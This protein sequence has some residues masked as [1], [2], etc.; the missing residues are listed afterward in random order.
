MLPQAQG[1]VP[2][3]GAAVAA[4]VAAQPLRRVHC[5]P[6]YQAAAQGRDHEQKRPLL[7]LRCMVRH[8]RIPCCCHPGCCS[9]Q[10][11]HAALLILPVDR[12]P[13]CIA[14]WKGTRPNPYTTPPSAINWPLSG[15][16]PPND[17]EKRPPLKV[18]AGRNRHVSRCSSRQ[19]CKVRLAGELFCSRLNAGQAEGSRG[20]TA[21]A[22]G[23]AGN[24]R[25]C[26]VTQRPQCSRGLGLGGHQNATTQPSFCQHCE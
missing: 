11:Q 21:M 25:T 3:V 16:R 9:Q 24:D 1:R 14:A 7:L 26:W 22:A 18:E 19:V 2:A 6:C 8:R 20:R 5:W 12:T 15:P 17:S 13:G 10:V 23:G 4:A